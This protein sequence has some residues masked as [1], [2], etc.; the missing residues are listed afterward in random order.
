MNIKYQAIGS[1]YSLEPFLTVDSSIIIRDSLRLM[2]SSVLF[3]VYNFHFGSTF[4]FSC[5][6]ATHFSVTDCFSELNLGILCFFFWATTA[7]N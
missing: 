4:F 2:L 6:I 1:M 7:I 5:S 3:R